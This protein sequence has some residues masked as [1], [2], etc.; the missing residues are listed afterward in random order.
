MEVIFLL[1]RFFFS[2][3]RLFAFVLLFLRTGKLRV[4]KGPF[5]EQDLLDELSF[6]GI[7]LPVFLQRDEFL[8]LHILGPAPGKDS[9]VKTV[10]IDLYGRCGFEKDILELISKTYP[11]RGDGE[12]K[13]PLELKH[14]NRVE[15]RFSMW[16][17]CPTNELQLS[18]ILLSFLTQKCGYEL[19]TSNS[20]IFSNLEHFKTESTYDRLEYTYFLKRT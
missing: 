1:T 14:P 16:L 3:P 5:C 15:N 2:D 17:I 7:K 10:Q 11:V 6:F 4:D 13:N 8:T 19:V 12:T 20:I 18:H 9:F